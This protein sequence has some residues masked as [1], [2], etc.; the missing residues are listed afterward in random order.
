MRFKRVVFSSAMVGVALWPALARA[1]LGDRVTEALRRGSLGAFALVFVGGVLTSLTPCV[2]PM[3]PITLG[4]FGARGKDVRRGRAVAL[5]AT[6][7]A[8]ICAMYSGLGVGSA[9]AGRAFGT[10]MASPWVMGP[11]AL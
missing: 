3:I 5:A 2:Y 1:D 10:F 4:I 8:G 6:Y 7:V 11:I 9:L